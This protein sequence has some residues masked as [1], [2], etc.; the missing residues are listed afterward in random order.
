MS[1]DWFVGYYEYHNDAKNSHKFYEI[2]DNEDGT[3]HTRWGRI[4]TKGQKGGSIVA[5][6]AQGKCEA[7][8]RRGYV[9][10]DFMVDDLKN[11]DDAVGVEEYDN[12]FDFM[13][14][15]RNL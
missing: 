2:V 9:V 1:K 10:V 12:E 6:H 14:E 7:K 4:G 11:T 15:L 3:Y 5:A 8:L 13:E